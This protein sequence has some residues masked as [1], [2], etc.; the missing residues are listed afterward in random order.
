MYEMWTRREVYGEEDEL[1]FILAAVADPN[2]QPPMRPW[3]VPSLM[4]PDMPLDFADLILRATDNNPGV[5]P[6]FYA[7]GEELKLMDLSAKGPGGGPACVG[8]SRSSLALSS[9]LQFPPRMAA[10]LRSGRVVEPEA[11]DDCSIFVASIVA[12]D[13]LALRMSKAV[14]D[15]LIDRLF[16]SFDALASAY[17]LFRIATASADTCESAGHHCLMAVLP[18]IRFCIQ[19]SH[20]PLYF[21]PFFTHSL[22][23]K[24]WWWRG[25]RS[26]Q[27]TT[28]R[29]SLV[30][31]W[32]PSPR[33]TP[34]W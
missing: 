15:D 7:I 34:R 32:Q 19:P 26:P 14:A 3:G 25:C 10:A 9:I 1:V 22:S 18:P 5:R 29:T 30:S 17:G 28:A 23:Q 8:E 16:S 31:P 20:A 12:Y 21:S 24:I 27:S 33:P 2:H 13:E 4:P 11:F 6:D